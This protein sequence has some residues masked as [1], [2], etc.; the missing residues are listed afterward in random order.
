[1]TASLADPWSAGMAGLAVWPSFFVPAEGSASGFDPF[2]E[3]AEGPRTGS[4][5]DFVPHANYD[6]HGPLDDLEGGHE[7]EPQVPSE[8]MARGR[9][10]RVVPAGP[11]RLSVS[12]RSSPLTRPLLVSHFRGF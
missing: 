11:C 12:S 6:R 5:G 3:V 1:V 10:G 2:G 8:A 4:V 9:V 7:G